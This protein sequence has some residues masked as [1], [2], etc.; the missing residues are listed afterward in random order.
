MIPAFLIGVGTVFATAGTVGAFLRSPKAAEKRSA[1]LKFATATLTAR[2]SHKLDAAEID[3]A[4]Q[5]LKD[6]KRLKRNVAAGWT[7]EG[8]KAAFERV[9]VYVP[10]ARSKCI[11]EKGIEAADAGIA[12]VISALESIRPAKRGGHNDAR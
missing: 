6:I 4:K 8:D 11:V 1:Y 3:Q 10:T 7:S 2:G 9:L 12:S 5:I